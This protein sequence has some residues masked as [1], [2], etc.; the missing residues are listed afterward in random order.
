M[1]NRTG[2]GSGDN[3]M[4]VSSPM[5]RIQVRAAAVQ[6]GDA[7]WLQRLLGLAVALW[8]VC[9]DQAMRSYVGRWA[10]FHVG[11][12]RAEARIEAFLLMDQV[13]LV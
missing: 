10:T 5:E 8:G 6:I 13:G 2:G 9:W 11:L 4:G 7:G 12:L 3:T 1:N